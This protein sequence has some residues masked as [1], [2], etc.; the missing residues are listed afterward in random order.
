MEEITPGI[1]WASENSWNKH[2][3][4]LEIRIWLNRSKQWKSG[5][6]FLL[7]AAI[8]LPQVQET[9]A[10][11][12]TNLGKGRTSKSSKAFLL[13][14]KHRQCSHLSSPSPRDRETPSLEVFKLQLDRG[15]SLLPWPWQ[16]GAQDILRP[17]PTSSLLQLNNQ[18]SPFTFCETVFFHSSLRLDL[19]PRYLNASVALP[20]FFLE[21]NWEILQS[22]TDFNKIAVQAL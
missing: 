17:L 2:R 5:W 16:A 3:G 18:N 9:A 14:R 20:F 15:F 6:L 22:F 4:S 7:T 8:D 19:S 12:G 11:L 21:K 10:H 13:K 1:T